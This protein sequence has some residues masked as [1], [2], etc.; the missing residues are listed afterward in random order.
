MPSPTYPGKPEPA[1]VHKIPVV[2]ILMILDVCEP[3]EQIY[4]L[5]LL[6]TRR[7]VGE[8]NRVTPVAGTLFQGIRLGSQLPDG[9][10]PPFPAIHVVLPDGSVFQTFLV[11]CSNQ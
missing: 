2:S 6:L 10:F 5:P 8:L 4:M 11:V 3:C 9:L 1:T 7:S